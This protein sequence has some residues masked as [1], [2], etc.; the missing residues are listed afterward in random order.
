MIATPAHG[1]I[2]RTYQAL[3]H[4]PRRHHSRWGP[5]PQAEHKQ[6]VAVCTIYFIFLTGSHFPSRRHRQSSRGRA[7]PCQRSRRF[8]Y[9]LGLRQRVSITIARIAF[10]CTIFHWTYFV[11]AHSWSKLQN[12]PEPRCMGQLVEVDGLLYYVGGAQAGEAKGVVRSCSEIFMYDPLAE[13][14]DLVAQ[15]HK[16]RHSF[17]LAKSGKLD[18][19]QW[20]SGC[21]IASQVA[22]MKNNHSSTV[23]LR[24]RARAPNLLIVP[25]S[26]SVA[27][28]ARL[29]LGGK[30]SSRLVPQAVFSVEF[31]K[32][33]TVRK[34][35]SYET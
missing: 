24:T 28:L 17:A 10:R 7:R 6:R 2:V 1:N 32:H 5:Q 18:N 9:V 22:F 4:R 26:S 23:L 3:A 11:Y 12:L 34:G 15:M 33:F 25:C 20:Y 14:W 19:R 13:R 27:R 31:E 16:S 8:S 21:T 29:F 35:N 30:G